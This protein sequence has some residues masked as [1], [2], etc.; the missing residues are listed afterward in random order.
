[1]IQSQ[2][3]KGADIMELLELALKYLEA[4]EEVKAE[5]DLILKDF[6]SPFAYQ[7]EVVNTK[8]ESA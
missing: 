5:I 4:S 6:R 3:M 2:K 7:G 1:M 8:Q